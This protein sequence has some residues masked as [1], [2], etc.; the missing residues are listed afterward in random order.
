MPTGHL[1]PEC[2]SRESRVLQTRKGWRSLYRERSCANGHTYWTKEQYVAEP[3]KEYKTLW[4]SQK[5]RIA[6]ERH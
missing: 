4:N 1:C 5:Y 6:R 2:D 3:P